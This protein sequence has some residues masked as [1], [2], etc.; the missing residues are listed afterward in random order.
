MGQYAMKPVLEDDALYCG[1]NGRILCGACSGCS[2]RYSGRD[3]S[4]HRVVRLTRADAEAFEAD[5]K[6]YGIDCACSCEAGGKTM[7][8]R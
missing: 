8:G 7:E 3:I 2:A 1:D 6:R 4:G 5:M